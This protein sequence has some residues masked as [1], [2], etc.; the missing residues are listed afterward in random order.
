MYTCNDCGNLN[1]SKIETI[2]NHQH[3][4]DQ[5]RYGCKQD[6]EFICGWITKDSELKTMGCSYWRAKIKI[7]QETL[8]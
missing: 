4:V 1:T 7:I 2:K 6:R 3:Y 5:Y 8:F